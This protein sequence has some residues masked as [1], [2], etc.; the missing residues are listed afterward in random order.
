MSEQY[1]Y[2]YG[3]KGQKWGVRRFQNEDM[4]LTPA[5]KERYGVGEKNKFDARAQKHIDKIATSKTR[6]GKSFHNTRAMVNE[7]KSNVRNDVKNAKGIGKKIGARLG[8]GAS[9]SAYD[10]MENYYSR[11]KDYRKTKLGK[12]LSGVSAYNAHN[13][14]KASEKI[15]QAKGIMGKGRASVEGAF[16]TK[17]KSITGRNTRMGEAIANSII[18]QMTSNRVNV[19]ALLDVGYLGMKAGQALAGGK[20]KQTASA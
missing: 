8:A 20:K 13:L 4:S 5:G 10:A 2:H 11:Q 7:Y 9:A 14:G 6:I 15:Y 1:L 16:G 17:V 19:T 18:M 12:H 3:I